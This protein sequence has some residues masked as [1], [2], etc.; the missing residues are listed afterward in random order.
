[1][2]LDE[3][4]FF[5]GIDLTSSE[6]RPSAWAVLSVEGELIHLGFFHR[7]GELLGEL[8]G[9]PHCVVGID[10]PLSLPL[11]MCCLEEACPCR[12]SS[13]FKGR[14]AERALSKMGIGCFYTTKKSIIRTM[15]YR[16]MALA[17]TLSAQG[18]E[19]IEVY[20]Y[21]T[22]VRL[23]GKVIPSKFKAEGMAF[24]KKRICGIIP[25]SSTRLSTL[26]HDQCDALLAAYTSYL[27]GRSQ[28]EAVGK[29][30]EG[31]MYLPAKKA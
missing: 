30:R 16:A 6:A 11:G 22:K 3:P 4:T 29:P 10:A 14:W 9:Y 8:R 12:P 17:D 18:H 20:P 13:P 26:D 31:L 28:V 23:F 1:M 15:T 21:A 19:V 27:Y 24:L 25:S 2:T 5:V 7:E